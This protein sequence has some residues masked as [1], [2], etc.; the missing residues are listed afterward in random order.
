MIT[1]AVL[2]VQGKEEIANSEKRRGIFR[3]AIKN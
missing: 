1:I 2:D 3:K